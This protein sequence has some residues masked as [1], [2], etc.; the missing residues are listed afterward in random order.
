MIILQLCAMV[1]DYVSIS[2]SKEISRTKI[3]A[4]VNMVFV[5]A[6]CLIYT[7]VSFQPELY[8]VTA[9]FSVHFPFMFSVLKKCLTLLFLEHSTSFSK[10]ISRKVQGPSQMGPQTQTA[11]SPGVW[12]FS[13]GPPTHTSSRQTWE[14][15]DVC[16]NIP[17][18]DQLLPLSVTTFGVVISYCHWL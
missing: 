1:L 12:K 17:S 5:S 10:Q 15:T 6:I 16:D 3:P 9:F 7:P 14:S 18:S 4:T 11:A 8:E 2:Y 13:L